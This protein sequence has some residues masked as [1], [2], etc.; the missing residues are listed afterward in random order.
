M[1]GWGSRRKG[2]L[3]YLISFVGVFLLGLFVNQ[4]GGGELVDRG[5]L[6][7]SLV[8]GLVVWYVLYLAS[9]NRVLYGTA[10]LL[11]GVLLTIRVYYVHIL[12]LHIEPAIFEGMFDTSP[13]EVARL[14]SVKP[15][16]IFVIV[17]IYLLVVA[18]FGWLKRQHLRRR[19]LVH[20]AKWGVAILVLIGYL[21]TTTHVVPGGITAVVEEAFP[22]RILQSLT[23][24]A[25]ARYRM[26]KANSEKV[27]LTTR[28]SFRLSDDNPVIVVFMRG[29]SLRSRS[30]PID[31]DV[32][33]P[34]N[35]LPDSGEYVFLDNVFS[36]ANYTQAAVPWMLSRSVG[37]K[38]LNEKSFISVLKSLGFDTTWLGCDRSD[39]TSFAAPIV[40]YSLEADRALFAGQLEQWVADHPE[41]YV[42]RLVG[43]FFNDSMQIA[44]L[45]SDVKKNRD[46]GRAF[47]W[48][49]MNGSHVPWRGFAEDYIYARPICDRVLDEVFEC[50]EKEAVNA[51]NST[52]LASQHALRLLLEALS[53]KNSVV[54]FAADHGESTGE[55]GLYGHGFMLPEGSRHI[56][57]QVNPAMMVWMSERFAESHKDQLVA[58]KENAGSYMRH[59]VIFHS[60]LDV[61]GVESEVIDRSKS[62]F[63]R[64]FV[65]R[66]RFVEYRYEV[67]GGKVIEQGYN[68]LVFE[69]DL[70][71]LS[72]GGTAMLK[73]IFGSDHHHVMLTLEPDLA[74]AVAVSQAGDRTIS[75]EFSAL[76]KRMYNISVEG[77]GAEGVLLQ[78]SS[79][80]AAAPAL[81]S[82]ARIVLS[83]QEGM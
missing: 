54:V 41:G 47:Y 42:F 26:Y 37:D 38:L 39:V 75:S 11:L 58:L 5:V 72:K 31:R 45:L 25:K 78:F 18:E 63:S 50:S 16:V 51:Y 60:I 68:R 80:L 33:S 20:G 14:G 12:G 53:D 19:L 15:L 65:S 10:V 7:R 29:E 49:E 24:A 55:N 62:V 44:Y 3:Y 30:F 28:H 13:D 59:D 17:V 23:E 40:N 74:I 48:V 6:L 32:I 4:E 34:V 73:L 69:I 71:T 76:A 2:F 64:S 1:R 70:Q 66:P 36:Y 52:I 8:T 9:F 35:Q 83:F 46:S 79:D 82:K 57:D 22:G 21:V 67:L 27:D 77:N 56:R 61:L 81:A 43:G